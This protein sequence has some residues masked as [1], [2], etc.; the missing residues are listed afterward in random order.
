MVTINV[1][2]FTT[3]PNQDMKSCYFTLQPAVIAQLQY[4]CQ[5]P[6]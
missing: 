1:L 6:M 3:L 4:N 2:K 5:L